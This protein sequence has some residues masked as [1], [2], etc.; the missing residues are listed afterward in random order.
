[1]H[2]NVTLYLLNTY[3]YYSTKNVQQEVCSVP[4]GNACDVI[5]TGSLLA[6]DYLITFHK[7]EL[8]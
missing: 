2:W 1:M 6:S 8:L 4:N 5:I 7:Y 3:P